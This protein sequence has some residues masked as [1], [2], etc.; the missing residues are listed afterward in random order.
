MGIAGE[1]LAR[2]AQG[3]TAVNARKVLREKEFAFMVA[4]Y[5]TAQRISPESYCVRTNNCKPR[6]TQYQILPGSLVFLVL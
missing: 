3:I 6:R 1:A 5:L 4:S 2:H